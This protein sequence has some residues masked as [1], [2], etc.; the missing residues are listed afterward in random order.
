M[1][2][3]HIARHLSAAGKVA[4]G[5]EHFNDAIGF[6]FPDESI[7]AIRSFF[8]RGRRIEDGFDGMIVKMDGL[9]I[10]RQKI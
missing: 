6:I 7:W 10:I 1:S 8:A 3:S 5:G 9:V 2:G 4:P